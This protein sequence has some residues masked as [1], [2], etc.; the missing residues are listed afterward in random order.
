M[1]G[2]SRTQTHGGLENDAHIHLSICRRRGELQLG[3]VAD[4]S[5]NWHRDYY[6]MCHYP[7]AR[8]R[9]PDAVMRQK[10]ITAISQRLFKNG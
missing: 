4:R 2:G 6:V 1:Q 8:G 5:G 9:L 7:N 3:A 10:I